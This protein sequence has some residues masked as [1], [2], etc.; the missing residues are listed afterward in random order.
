MDAVAIG[1]IVAV[2]I[3]IG[4]VVFLAMRIVYLINHTNS[5]D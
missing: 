5:K 4:I 2:A 1:S 3:T